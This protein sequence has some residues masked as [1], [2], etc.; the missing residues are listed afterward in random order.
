MLETLKT[1]L[2][3]H[4]VKL[5]RKGANG[6]KLHIMKGICSDIQPHPGIHDHYSIAVMGDD[7]T[8]TVLLKAEVIT[9]KSVDGQVHNSNGERCKVEYLRRAA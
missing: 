2:L 9:D 7:F 8:K 4:Q 1:A 5:T 3:G 6:N